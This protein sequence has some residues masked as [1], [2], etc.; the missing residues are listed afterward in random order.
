MPYNFKEI[1]KRLLKLWYKIVR[2]NWSHVI[3]SNWIK[4]IPVPN[5][6]WKDIS[7]WVENKIIKNT[8]ISKI[9]FKNF[10]F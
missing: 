2:Q 10:D 6:P 4:T 5:H 8:W 9:E 3:F 7:P 1:N